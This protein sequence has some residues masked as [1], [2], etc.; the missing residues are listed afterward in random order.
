MQNTE[1]ELFSQFGVAG[2]SRFYSAD[3]LDG[4]RSKR[5]ERRFMH[6]CCLDA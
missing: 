2:W 5:A 4:E 3:L 6:S 1:R